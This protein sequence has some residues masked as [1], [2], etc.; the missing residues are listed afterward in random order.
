MVKRCFICGLTDQET[1][2]QNHHIVPNRIKTRIQKQNNILPV[3]EKCHVGIHNSGSRLLPGTKH[4]NIIRKRA[5]YV[6][7]NKDF[8]ELLRFSIQITI[9][10]KLNDIKMYHEF[11]EYKEFHSIR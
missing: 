4:W 5:S 2:I 11:L 7:N 6:R 10:D 3:C 1:T 9:I 8:N